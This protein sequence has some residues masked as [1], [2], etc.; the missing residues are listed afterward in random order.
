MIITF[1]LGASTHQG[2]ALHRSAL[3]FT[4]IPLSWPGIWSRDPATSARTIT[5]QLIGN[6]TAFVAD[7]GNSC[8]TAN[9]LY[10]S[11]A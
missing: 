3:T 10:K 2:S 11:A 9:S 1:S 7:I 4:F 5:T 6:Y 8:C